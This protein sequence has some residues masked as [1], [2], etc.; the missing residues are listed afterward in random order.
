MMYVN[1]KEAADVEEVL[2]VVKA[3]KLI[4]EVVTTV[5][6]DVNAASVQDIPITTDEAT[7]VS[8]LRKRRGIIIQDPK[9]TRTTVT[10]QPKVQ[11]KDKG[12]AILIKEPK[13]LKRKA[14]I[15][16]DE[17]VTR[18]LE[19]KLNVDINWNDLIKQV[20]RSERLTDAIMKY[21]AL[22][23]KPLTEAQVRRNMIVYLKNMAG[24]KMDYFKEMSYDEIRPLFEKQYNYNQYFLNEVNK[25][26]KVPEKEVSQEKEVEVESSKRVGKSLEQ[27]IPKETKDRARDCKA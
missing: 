18:Q 23:R 27:E 11:A 6:V 20:K 13:P 16:L 12:K 17:K 2:E 21:Q 26:V 4:T 5:G 15:K 1:D 10:V 14:Q 24:Y 8:V 7:K 3:A 25:G 19:A 22:K 9:E